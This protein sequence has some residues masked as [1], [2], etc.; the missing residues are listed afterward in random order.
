MVELFCIWRNNYYASNLA[1]GRLELVYHASGVSMPQE[2]LMTRA[3][4][5][6]LLVCY[7]HYWIKARS[8]V[9]SRYLAWKQDLE[10]GH[11]GSSRLSSVP[12]LCRDIWLC[13]VSNRSL[14]GWVQLYLYCNLW[15]RGTTWSMIFHIL[16][17]INVSF[18]LYGSWVHTHV[19]VHLLVVTGSIWRNWGKAPDYVT[20]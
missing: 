11:D 20:V 7:C 8:S 14:A 18:S 15:R 9:R 1:N 3:D 13:R 12:S 6:K 4:L 10:H 5:S 19:H 2:A 16:L 17:L